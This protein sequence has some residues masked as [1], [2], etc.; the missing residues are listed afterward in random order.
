[1]H[2]IVIGGGIIGLTTAY[3]LAREGRAVTVVD[4]R[5]MGQGAS[6]VNAGWV[7]PA[8]AGPVPAPGMVLSSL[9]WMVRPDS[10]LCIRP[11]VRP[12][13]LRFMLGMWRHSNA[14][15]HRRG[16]EAHLRLAHGSMDLLDEYRADG[17]AFEM[18]GDGLLMV[19]LDGARLAHHTADLDLPRSHGLEPRVL[20][21]DAVREH[22]PMLSDRVRGG[23]H[24]PHERYLDPGALVAALRARLGS[25]GVELVEDAPVDDVTVI[26]DR[27]TA[28]SSRG[29]RFDADT[30][31]LAAGAWT[32]QLSA[33]FGEPL[34]VRSGKGYCVDTSP[35][36]LRGAVNLSEAKVAV[37]PLDGRLRLAGTMELGGLDETIDEA[38]VAAIRRAPEAYFRDWEPFPG[39]TVARAGMRPMTPDG[40]PVIGRLGR[41]TNAYVSTGHGMLG[42]TLAPGTAAALTELIVHG[43]TA[44]ALE[45]FASARFSGR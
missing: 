18:H 23:I 41:L 34:P 16:F 12:D 20:V 42:V 19:F 10:P 39:A 37:T 31:V 5:A 44:P 36:P 35:L 6:D 28:I 26:G 45:P 25:L 13:F 30:Y 17:L 29:R 14:R 8:V 24:F 33:R 11:S 27:V 9:R 38:R 7:V 2:T 32:G 40:L 15:D 43:R 4:A 22:E 1:M 21:G 3:H